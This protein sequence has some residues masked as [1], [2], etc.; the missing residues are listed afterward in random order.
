MPGIKEMNSLVKAVLMKTLKAATCLVAALGA[1]ATSFYVM[2]MLISV[3]M[4]PAASQ[5]IHLSA[6]LKFPKQ[7]PDTPVKRNE[8]KKVLPTQPPVVPDEFA[9]FGKQ[10]VAVSELITPESPVGQVDFDG[11]VVEFVPHFEDLVATRIVQPVYPPEA[12]A[13]QIEG[14]VVVEFSVEEDGRVLNPYVVESKPEQIF[15]RAALRAIREFRFKPAEVDDTAL[16]VDAVIRF[17]FRLKGSNSDVTG[18]HYP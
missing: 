1:T 7:L 12:K 15:D 18:D 9:P 4:E 14:H 10:E 16:L 17:A 11:P 13:R 3:K 5:E 2:H 8:L 6:S